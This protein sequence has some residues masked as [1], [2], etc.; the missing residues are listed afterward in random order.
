MCVSVKARSFE[1]L[2]GCVG[3]HRYNPH[4]WNHI[5]PFCMTAAVS[6]GKEAK[7]VVQYIGSRRCTAGLFSGPIGNIERS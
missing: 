6:I 3:V 5:L 7:S 1:V 4:P 2:N